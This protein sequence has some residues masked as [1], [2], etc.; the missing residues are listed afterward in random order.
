MPAGV[1]AK[2]YHDALKVLQSKEGQER[3]AAEAVQD[4][5]EGI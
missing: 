1:L 4:A 2:L 3:K 5:M